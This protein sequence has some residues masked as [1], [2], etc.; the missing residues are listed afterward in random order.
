[1]ISGSVVLFTRWIPQAMN[2][3]VTGVPGNIVLFEG[4]SRGNLFGSNTSG[5]IKCFGC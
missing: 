5:D 3:F 4:Y 2:S 1:M